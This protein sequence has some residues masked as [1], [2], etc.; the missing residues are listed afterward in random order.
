MAK[1]RQFTFTLNKELM[2][3]FKEYSRDVDRSM[4]GLLNSYILDLKEGCESGEFSPMEDIP[5]SLGDL[6]DFR[7]RPYPPKDVI[8]ELVGG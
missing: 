8:S 3:W 4:S 5:I 6:I 1:R 7:A 2:E